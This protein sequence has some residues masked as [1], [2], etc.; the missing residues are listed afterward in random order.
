MAFVQRQIDVTFQLG[1]GVFGEDGVSDTVTL[2]GHRVQVDVTGV[3]GPGM[4]VANARIYGVKPTLWQQL[5]S[6]NQATEAIRRNRLV[7]A[8]GDVG[9]A[10]ATVF[11]GQ[12]TLSQFDANAQPDTA[13]NVTAHAGLLE[14]VKVAKPKS[15]PGAAGADVV[16]YNLAQ[17]MGLAFENGG[18]TAVFS[19]LYLPPASPR[20]Q[21]ERVAQAARAEFV[22]DGQTLAVWPKGGSRG[23]LIPVISPD[24]G[25]VGYPNYSTS[26]NGGWL[27]VTTLFNPNIRLGGVVE[28]QSSLKV[29]NGKWVTHDIRHELDAEMPGGHWFTRFEATIQTGA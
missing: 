18:V 26:N 19:K 29:A 15:Y 5:A 1:R 8:A 2:Q 7:I 10:L 6:L 12:I 14:A 11:D 24:T 23:G 25:M 28:V 16:L 9:A 4:G 20:E 27:S 22:I 17:E 21:V 13:L 3:Y